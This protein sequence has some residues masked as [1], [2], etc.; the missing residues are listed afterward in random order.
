PARAAA[1]DRL[2]ESVVYKKLYLTGGIGAESGHEGFGPAYALPNAT[3]YNE[4]CAAI[5]SAL[6]NHR[7]FLLHGD[8]R[9]IDVL[10]RTI[11][12]GFLSGVSLGGDRF[13]YPN[14][15]ESDGRRPFNS[16]TA[17]RVAW[18]NC[19][20][21][22]GNVVRF[23][24]E[25]PGFVSATRGET[26]YV[27]LYAAGNA[28]VTMPGGSVAL[29]Q[30]TRY[31]WEGAVRLTVE[32]EAESAFA[33]ALRIPGWAQ[34]HPVPGDLY[35]YLNPRP[36]KVSLKVNGRRAAWTMD[37]GYAVLRRT[38]RKGD[39][40]ELDLPMPVRRVV[41]H[42]A[43]AADAGRVALERGPLVYCVEGIDH[44]GAALNLILPDRARVSTGFQ[45]ELLGGVTVLRARARALAHGAGGKAIEKTTRLTAV[46][47]CV[48][49]NRGAGE[50]AVWLPRE[51]AG[52]AL[53]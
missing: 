48:W 5:A 39:V 47:Y 14:P 7:L 38:W 49:S 24:P 36:G 6:W 12:N 37:K 22:P 30:A 23:L 11:Y 1:G 25:V 43:V 28:R 20:C 19:S 46:P 18:F 35:R 27:N 53:P 13:F 32:P 26:L 33:L 9:Y 8:A 17:T 10:E 51:A 50:M 4:T 31:P 44:G 21:C 41:A 29:A 2:W 52:A 40:I 34:G 16:G 15:L 45:P 3:A 42:P